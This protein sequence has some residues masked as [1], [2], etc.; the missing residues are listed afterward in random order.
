MR[1]RRVRW[2]SGLAVLAVLTAFAQP[3]HAED[4][5]PAQ[6]QVTSFSGAYLAARVAEADNDLDS[7]IDF[8]KQALAFAPDDS[9]LQQSVMLTLIA[10][11][12]FD[13]A[14]PYADKLKEVPE[15][16]RFSRLVLAVDSFKKK[17]Y[18]KA[19]YW[20]KLSLAADI[21]KL[22]T[23]VMAGVAAGATVV[24][25]STGDAGHGSPGALRAAG[26]ARSIADM[27]ELPALLG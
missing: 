5:K 7:A 21:N 19:Q 20:L 2:L 17:D 22:S 23:G 3:G 24:G 26:A 8:Y 15:V 25:Y 1:Q 10:Q 6:I 14:L 4:K 16:E 13:E 11:G 18:E 12:R 27:A 9:S